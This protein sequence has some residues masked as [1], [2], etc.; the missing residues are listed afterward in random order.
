LPN[1][2]PERSQGFSLS[3]PESTLTTRIERSTTVMDMLLRPSSDPVEPIDLALATRLVS[4]IGTPD[5]FERAADVIEHVI[6]TAGLW[7]FQFFTQQRPR[8]V[9]VR[10]RDYEDHSDEYVNG[11]Y[12]FDPLYRAFVDGSSSGLIRF[13]DIAP[14]DFNS[15][16]FYRDYYARL[17]ADDEI[18]LLFT[19]DDGWTFAFVLGRTAPGQPFSDEEIATLRRVLPLLGVC[20]N[21]HSKMARLAL[22]PDAIDDALQRRINHTMKNFAR[23]LLTPREHEV[24]VCMLNGYSAP[25]TAHRLGVAEGT[26]KVHRRSIHQKLEIS[27]QAELFSLV[28][29]CIS[30]A[31]T[32]GNRDPLHCYQTRKAVSDPQATKRSV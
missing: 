26:V 19:T 11:R 29:N 28:V 27:T 9:L 15:S 14:S 6:D 3:T 23:S 5:F 24:L 8:I 30:L 7:T 13:R 4:A 20:I 17:H 31:D 18:D 32:E 16:E 10:N 21:N 12:L 2:L 1:A 25:L 22:A